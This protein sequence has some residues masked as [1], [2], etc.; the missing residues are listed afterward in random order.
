MEDVNI[1]HLLDVFTSTDPNAG[2]IWDACYHFLIHL[3]WN[4]PRL[5]TL[6]SK[7]EALADDHP[8]KPKCLS[9]IAHLFEGVGNYA[10]K[11]RLMTQ[12]LEL[13]RRRGNDVQVTATLRDL[14]DANR[15]LHLAEEGLQQAKEALE[16]SERISGVVEQAWCLNGLAH[17]LFDS[18][19]LI[20]AKDAASRA[21]DLIA[22]E[23][24]E[25]L[26]CRLNRMLGRIFD[27]LGEKKEAIHHFE[28]ALRIASS[29]SWYNE[30]FWIHYS[31]AELFDDEGELEDA[32]TH[33]E[34]AK[35][36]AVDGALPY[37]LARATEMQAQLWLQQLR[38]ED[39]K[40]EALHSL[41]IYEKLG[42]AEG[43]SDSKDLLQEIERTMEERSSRP[44]WT[45]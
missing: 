9:R 30:L 39:A 38:L 15:L 7:I 2:G 1:E 37:E 26:A 43:V 34:L 29:F 24:Q 33:I 3:Y 13:E 35:S 5:T 4:K 14:S 19:Q 6:K 22:E 31:L 8:S 32:I 40:S 21:I 23:D 27:S 28:M 12:V 36:H 25:H 10:E 11:K 20:A 45:S 17:V 18:Q 16:I 41:E 42:V 44:R